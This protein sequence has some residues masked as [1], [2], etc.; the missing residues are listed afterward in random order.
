MQVEEVAQNIG[1][2]INEIAFNW[3]RQKPEVTS[4]IGGASSVE[5]LTKNVKSTEWDLDEA[6][7]SKLESILK[8][9]A[10]DIGK[11]GGL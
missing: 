1:H 3:L 9:F 4:I 2:P 11:K 5:Q 6:A 8:P 7:M 10:R